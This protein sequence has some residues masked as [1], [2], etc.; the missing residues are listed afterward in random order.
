LGDLTQYSVQ[1]A[2]GIGQHFD[3]IE[4]LQTALNQWLP[5]AQSILVKGSRFMKMERIVQ[6]LQNAEQLNKGNTTCC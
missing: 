5:H 4:S 2:N 6:S 3:S 1:Q